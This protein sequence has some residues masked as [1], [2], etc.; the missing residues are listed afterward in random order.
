MGDV[1]GEGFVIKV[2]KG[3]QIE[4]HR[5]AFDEVQSIEIAKSRRALKIALVVLAGVAIVWI[6]LYA[7]VG[8]NL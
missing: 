3:D 4:E 8:R 5:I 2:A 7:T 6:V 1:T